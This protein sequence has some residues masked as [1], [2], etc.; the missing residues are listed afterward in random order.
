MKRPRFRLSTPCFA[1]VLALSCLVLSAGASRAATPTGADPWAALEKVRGRLAA[2]G[3]RVAQFEHLYVP[4]GFTQG[5]RESGRLALSLPDCLRWDYGEPYPKSFLVCGT[6]AHYWNSEDKT[7]HRQSIDSRNEPGLDLL[8]LG[9]ENLKG[10]YRATAEEAA[11]GQ[12]R[13]HL[14]P[15]QPMEEVKEAILTL[16]PGAGVVTGLEYTDGEG[17]LTRFV[18]QTYS[19]LTETDLFAPPPGI[20]WQESDKP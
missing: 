20:D 19:P 14:V 9:T 5:E 10:R 7:G 8:L 12:L 17:N 13:I 2:S 18:L 11:G 6:V 15:L 1:T 16:D 3:P 4:A